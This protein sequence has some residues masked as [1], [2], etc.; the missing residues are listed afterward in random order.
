MN[1]NNEDYISL[2]G[3]KKGSFTRCTNCEGK[4]NCENAG[5]KVNSNNDCVPF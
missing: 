4:Q 1:Q 2:P 3:C 5:C